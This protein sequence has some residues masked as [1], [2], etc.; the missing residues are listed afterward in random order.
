MDTRPFTFILDLP[1]ESTLR[2]GVF[3]PHT[4]LL[5]SYKEANS[6]RNSYHRSQLNRISAIET[7]KM[8]LHHRSSPTRHPPRQFEVNNSC[9]W[10]LRAASKRGSL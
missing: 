5:F 2:L 4:S 8:D 6:K 1:H 9:G 3:S 10:L 7:F